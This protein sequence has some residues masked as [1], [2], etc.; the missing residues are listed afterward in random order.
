MDIVGPSRR[1]AHAPLLKMR[2][3][4][5]RHPRLMPFVFF[6]HPC[7]SDRAA[8]GKISDAVAMGRPA[9]PGALKP[10]AQRGSSIVG[11]LNPDSRVGRSASPVEQGRVR[12]DAYVGIDV[13]KD[14]L[15]VH[16]EPSGESF[17]VARDGEG[18]AGLIERLQP[19]A[20]RLIAI[21]ATGGF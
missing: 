8:W 2:S 9:H 18:L 12:M 5:F 15:D 10:A 21:E 6:P 17:A 7:K 1:G 11:P 3:K 19:L 13:S 20:P 14:R 4:F 16:V